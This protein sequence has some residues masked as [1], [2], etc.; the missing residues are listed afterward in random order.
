MRL[1]KEV[2]GC[3]I[4]ADHLPFAPKP[5]IQAAAT[6]RILIIGQAPG[7][8]VQEAGFPWA[9]ASGDRLREWTGLKHEVF[10]DPAKVALMPMGLCYPGSTKSGDLPPRPEC[11]P[12]WHPR[13]LSLLPRL[14]IMILV[15]QYAQ[16]RYLKDT[17]RRSMTE[18]VR[19]FVEVGPRYF[20]LP[21]PSWR[22]TLWLRKNPWFEADVLPVL[23]DRTKCALEA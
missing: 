2:R 6:A 16:A 3:T 12:Q 20:P 7:A 4:C 17:R 8:R 1:L 22:S 9:D 15:G 10:Y 13:V 18:C 19:Q 11:A 14:R 23:R 21:H 5:I